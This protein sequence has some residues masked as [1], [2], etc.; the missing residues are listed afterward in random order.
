MKGENMSN[1][2][3]FI[4][5]SQMLYPGQFDYS[6]AV[7]RK[8]KEKVQLYC[9]L[10]VV[11]SPVLISPDHHLSPR[12]GS[13]CKQCKIE[14]QIKRNSLDQSVFIER[15]YK[16]YPEDFD[17]SESVYVNAKTKISVVCTIHQQPFRTTPDE[18]Q[19]GRMAGCKMCV[20]INRR[21]GA[22]KAA[23]KR[24]L[25]DTAF[26]KKV[27]EA[28]GDKFVIDLSGYR[29]AKSKIGV[30]CTQ[31]GISKTPQADKFVLWKGCPVCDRVNPS[32]SR[33]TDEQVEE[34]V[35][36]EQQ[37]R[38]TV[39]LQERQLK[40]TDSTLSLTCKRHPNF[41]KTI[42]YTNRKTQ[43]QCDICHPKKTKTMIDMLAHQYKEKNYIYHDLDKVAGLVTFHCP[44][45]GLVTEII[46]KHKQ[47]GCAQCKVTENKEFFLKSLSQAQR[48]E[49]DYS[50]LVLTDEPL[51]RQTIQYRCLRHLQ[52]CEQKTKCHMQGISA[53]QKCMS[54]SRSLKRKKALM[55]KGPERRAE[56][57]A[58]A[59]SMWGEARYSY[60]NLEE[61]LFTFGDTITVYCHIH[62]S[63]FFCPANSHI[64]PRKDKGNVR[65]R[66]CPECKK[67][68]ARERNRHHFDKVV[69][70][71][72]LRGL[73]VL[74]AESDYKNG[75]S[76]LKVK[77]E[78]NHIT[79]PTVSKVMHAHLGCTKCRRSVGEDITRHLLNGY[80]DGNFV[81]IRFK[82][83]DSSHQYLEL[84]GFDEALGIA[85][86]Y[87]GIY[88]IE[89]D[90]HETREKWLNQQKRDRA[91]RMMCLERGIQL[92]EVM[93]FNR[94]RFNKLDILESVEM[95][96]IKA[97]F[98]YIPD[99]LP[100]VD[101][102]I[103]RVAKGKNYLVKLERICQEHNLTLLDE[104]VW[105]GE[106]H[107][108]RFK[109]N[110]CGYLFES[111]VH[112]RDKAKHKCCQKCARKMGG[113][114]RR[115][116]ES[117]KDK[118]HLLIGLAKKVAQLGVTLTSEKWLGC[119][120]AKV[121]EG[122]CYYCGESVPFFDYNKIMKKAKLCPCQFSERTVSVLKGG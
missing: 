40:I 109:C 44:I 28:H 76:R 98:E 74:S 33:L 42:K 3:E 77:C 90:V 106:H 35:T 121:Y 80:F 116:T 72:S 56:F 39:A 97:G 54:E 112:L 65:G 105:F 12:K 58:H 79:T 85:F 46:K 47:V 64:F 31:C 78:N 30:F 94:F 100:D 25:S 101:S 26:L 7:Y 117:K 13:G 114:N 27:H 63:E 96:L 60:P 20:Q 57:L 19:S 5:R 38:F 102:V 67:D 18:I 93:L 61:E 52:D 9:L 66:G 75:R 29:G 115:R 120:Y 81:K 59:K 108:Y 71:F 62:N 6:D 68:K 16:I 41:T 70:Y 113:G 51:H 34:T 89:P 8:A 69:D 99:R 83:T 48:E 122:V 10:H 82:P 118:S 32:V 107:Y 43:H 11:P 86:E 2:G 14:A 95:A 92:I 111:S 36:I 49:N 55:H 22:E 87:Q 50:G 1:T 73:T 23:D 53:C 103:K 4:K 88:H 84:D 104:A 21:L 45:H 37:G 24:R 119:G 110:S 15:A 91:T 17:F